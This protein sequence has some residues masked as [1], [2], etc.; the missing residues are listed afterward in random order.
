M[1]VQK[2]LEITK[3]KTFTT[4]LRLQFKEGGKVPEKYNGMYKSHAKAKQAI[5]EYKRELEEKKRYPSAPKTAEEAAKPRLE[6]PEPKKAAP[7]KAAPKPT[8]KVEQEEV[9]DDGEGKDIS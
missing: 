4:M 9:K 6:K 5:E 7:K 2:T 8:P 1:E 3:D